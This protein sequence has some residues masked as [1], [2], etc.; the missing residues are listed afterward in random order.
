MLIE[1]D[2][3]IYWGGTS[4]IHNEPHP[5]AGSVVSI[6]FVGESH[7]FEFHL[8][9]WWD[10]VSGKSWRVAPTVLVEWKYA[11][12]VEAHGMPLDDDVVYGKSH[13]V[14]LLVHVSEIIPSVDGV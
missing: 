9:D 3:E 12:Y 7:L 10:R 14:S 8:E 2:D 11:S 5:L 1:S 6:S 4:M 13:G